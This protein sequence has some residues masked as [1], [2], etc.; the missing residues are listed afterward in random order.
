MRLRIVVI[1]D[2]AEAR[3]EGLRSFVLDPV[4]AIPAA[5]VPGR[6]DLGHE[7]KWPL[8]TMRPGRDFCQAIQAV[9]GTVKTDEWIIRAP[10]YT[11]REL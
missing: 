2:V 3:R 5:P 4:Q 7:R 10:S 9:E 1:P 11:G 6:A 8:T